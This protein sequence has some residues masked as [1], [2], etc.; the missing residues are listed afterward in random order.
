MNYCKKC[1]RY[2]SCDYIWKNVNDPMCVSF[3][4]IKTNA[5]M[6]RAMSDEELANFIAIHMDCQICPARPD[7]SCVDA[8]TCRRLLLN[9]LKQEM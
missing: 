9:W 7:G 1:N 6:I 2:D 5:D 3:T 8:E 4:P